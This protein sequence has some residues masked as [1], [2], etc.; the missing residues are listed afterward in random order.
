MSK[1]YIIKWL[2]CNNYSNRQKL[3][4]E[5]FSKIPGNQPIFSN[6]LC[7]IIGKERQI[8]YYF[9][10]VTCRIESHT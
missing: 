10:F 5:G 7:G 1:S 9:G 3:K 8:F 4:V 2:L 6:S